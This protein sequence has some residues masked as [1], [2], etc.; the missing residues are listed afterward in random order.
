MNV[1]KHVNTTLCE[2]GVLGQNFVLEPEHPR[3]GVARRSGSSVFLSRRG[4]FSCMS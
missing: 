2:K 3:Q 1:L 4:P